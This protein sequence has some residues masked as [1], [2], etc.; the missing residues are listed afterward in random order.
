MDPEP[1]LSPI[2]TSLS[3]LIR[4][5]PSPERVQFRQNQLKRTE[6]QIDSELI[7]KDNSFSTSVLI[8]KLN[9][10][11]GNCGYCLRQ[12]TLNPNFTITQHFFNTCPILKKKDIKFQ[13][14][15]LKT[16]T[17]LEKE[18]VYERYSGCYKCKIPQD[19]CNRWVISESGSGFQQSEYQTKCQYFNI[20]P[21]W[22]ASILRNATRQEQDYIREQ[23]RAS[24][25]H[26]LGADKE[27]IFD[28][29]KKKIK[30]DGIET[31]GLCFLFCK[32][33]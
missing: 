4:T 32:L 26:G 5:P 1:T 10:Y 30:R 6:I 18:L 14:N 33:A 22:G 28:F 31:N 21:G 23:A 24:G 16:F 13:E 9:E 17:K 8:E 2:K 7:S 3:N 11:Q 29:L 20:L 27:K 25:V 19:I 12:Q 15:I